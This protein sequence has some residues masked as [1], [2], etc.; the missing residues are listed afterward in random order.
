MTVRARAKRTL[1]IPFMAPAVLVYIAIVVWPA[2]QAFNL[3]LF[4]WSGFGTSARFIALDNFRQIPNDGIFRLALLNNLVLLVVGGLGIFGFA[5]LALGVFPPRTRRRE[6]LR[7]LVFLPQVVPLIA[8]SVLWTFI[9]NYDFGLL[10]GFFRLVGLT[11]LAST[12]W[13]GPDL[14]EWAVVLALI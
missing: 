9:Y 5:F 6:T 3:S 8:L 13:M 4:D 7:T 1:I 11:G 10:N 14:I 12:V 2:I